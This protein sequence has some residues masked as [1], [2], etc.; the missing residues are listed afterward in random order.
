MFELA[1]MSFKDWY[2]TAFTL[3][4][5]PTGQIFRQRIILNDLT[6]VFAQ[7]RKNKMEVITFKFT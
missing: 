6:S 4:Q 3:R 2:P 5:E 1:K 7:F